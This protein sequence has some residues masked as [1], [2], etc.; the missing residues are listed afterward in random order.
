MDLVVLDTDVASPSYKRRL[1]GPMVDAVVTHRYEVDTSDVLGFKEDVIA[2]QQ[3]V[4]RAV[5]LSS[6]PIFARTG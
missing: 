2:E 1:P 5:G 4:Q 3:G 6:K